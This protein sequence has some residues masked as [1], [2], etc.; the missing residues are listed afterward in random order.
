MKRILSDPSKIKIV[1]YS[2]YKQSLMKKFFLKA[3]S[4]ITNR[5]KKNNNNQIL[6]NAYNISGFTTNKIIYYQLTD[7]DTNYIEINYFLTNNATH[8]QLIKDSQYFNYIIYI[9]NQTDE[10]S[11]YYELNHND[12]HEVHIKSLSS[13]YEVV[14]RS[15]IKFSIMI[16]LNHY[17]YNNTD[18]IISKVYNYINNIILYINSYNSSTF[19]DIRLEELEK[20]SEQNFTFTEDAHESIFY[21]ILSN[22]LFYKDDKDYLLKKMWFSKDDFIKNFDLV[23]FYFNQLT[24]NNYEEMFCLSKYTVEGGTIN[25]NQTV[26]NIRYKDNNGTIVAIIQI[27]NINKKIRMQNLGDVLPKQECFT[28]FHVGTKLKNLAKFKKWSTEDGGVNQFNGNIEM[29]YKDSYGNVMAAIITKSNGIF[30]TIA[31]YE[32]V[33]NNRSKMLLTNHYGQSIVIYD[34]SPE[35]NQITRMDIDTD[36]SIIE[37]TKIFS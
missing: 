3:F 36:G 11:L 14:L 21:K 29:R 19:N 27:D 30:D 6:P 33:N 31:E 16:Q 2:H 20:I 4:N 18:E 23:K 28:P 7:P 10:N 24:L 5:P 35:V 25:P 12:T 13:Y 22:N 17:S 9:L 8:E 26:R 32:Y 15:K 34:G 37:I 1:L